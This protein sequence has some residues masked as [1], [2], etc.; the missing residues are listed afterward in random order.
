MKHTGEAKV[1]WAQLAAPNGEVFEGWW[2]VIDG[3]N[4]PMNE[5]ALMTRR[6][7]DGAAMLQNAA[8]YI[9]TNCEHMFADGEALEH[10]FNL[11]DAAYRQVIHWKGIGQ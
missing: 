9:H 10:A 11:I 8:T 5:R 2:V 6:E 7:A 3:V 4:E 1:R